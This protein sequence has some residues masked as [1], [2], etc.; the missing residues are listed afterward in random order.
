M[1]FLAFPR[2]AL[3]FWF[4]LVF[5]VLSGLAFSLPC[6]ALLC[7]ALLCLALDF[8]VL[9]FLCSKVRKERE[10]GGGREGYPYAAVVID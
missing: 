6:L 7:L 9:L 5:L 10:D 4:R 3:S 1:G 8:L 2:L